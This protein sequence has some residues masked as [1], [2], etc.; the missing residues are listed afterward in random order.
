MHIGR[1][2]LRCTRHTHNMYP[3]HAHPQGYSPYGYTTSATTSPSSS[4]GPYPTYYYVPQ[5]IYQ[6]P[7]TSPKQPKRHSRKASYS[8][9][10]TPGG[11]QAPAGYPSPPAYYSTRPDHASPAYVSNFGFV[12]PKARRFS[13]SEARGGGNVNGPRRHASVQT[14]NQRIYNDTSDEADDSPTFSYIKPKTTYRPEKYAKPKANQYPSKQAPAYGKHSDSQPSRP[15]RSSQSKSTPP[16]PAKAAPPQREA[17]PADAAKFQ[18]PA[19]YSLKNWDPTETPV[20]LLGSIFDANSLGKW[21]YDWTVHT[22]G[23][24]TPFSDIAGEMWLLLIKLAHKMKR[25]DECVSRVDDRDDEH[26]LDEFLES[27]DRLWSRFK[28]LLKV[29]EEYMWQTASTSSKKESAKVKMGRNSGTEFVKAMFG[30]Q[31]EMDE[32]EKVMQGIRLWNMRFDANCESILRE[33][34]SR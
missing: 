33:T 5:P 28:K 6:S 14:Q 4:P 25:A 32:T 23:A 16:K 3:Y 24:D 22:H 12:K 20:V 29:C 15:R 10:H 18:I 21:I 13:T 26:M 8:S 30:P 31:K 27:G 11:W 17:T 9:P 7:T 34:R 19:G 2:R 1:H